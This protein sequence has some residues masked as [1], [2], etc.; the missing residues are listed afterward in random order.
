MEKYIPTVSKV[1]GFYGT[2]ES[3]GIL[4]PLTP[5]RPNITEWGPLAQA[6]LDMEAAPDWST[7]CNSRSREDSPRHRKDTAKVYGYNWET[8]E[9]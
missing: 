6:M 4:G 5:K 3:E 2:W 9:N 1:L 7:K 8:K